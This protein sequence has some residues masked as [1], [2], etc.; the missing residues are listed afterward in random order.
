[1]QT[2]TSTGTAQT[3]LGIGSSTNNA[4][5]SGTNVFTGTNIF[6]KSLFLLN[7]IRELGLFVTNVFVTNIVYS[8]N[9]TY[10]GTPTN[11]GESVYATVFVDVNLPPLQSSNSSVYFNWGWSVTNANAERTGALVFCGSNTNC[12]F[13]SPSWTGNGT[14]VPSMLN[15]AAVRRLLFSNFGS[16]TN[17]IVQS[18]SPT[19]RTNLTGFH[20]L[21]TSTN[22]N[23]KFAAH[24]FTTTPNSNY[25]FFV[26]VV[27]I[28]D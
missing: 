8:T 16:F 26:R 22:W 15:D 9:A 23:I 17:Q 18:T 12:V 2:V 4:L 19:F 27:E 24:A 11:A 20:L 6:P 14:T 7:G 10:P 28:V 3:Y 1:M 5:L 21:D 25:L 13:W